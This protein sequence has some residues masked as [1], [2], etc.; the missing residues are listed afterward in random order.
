[1]EV[2]PLPSVGTGTTVALW[3]RPANP[4]LARELPGV[5]LFTRE[6]EPSI[7]LTTVADLVELE[8]KEAELMESES[9][10]PIGS[11]DISPRLVRAGVIPSPPASELVGT[12]MIVIGVEPLVPDTTLTD[13]IDVD[14]MVGDKG[15]RADGEG[16]P[17][18]G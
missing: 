7:P 17:S 14:H 2:D 4:L 12:P 3:G 13:P 5:Q 15:I 11:F 6:V 16:E 9:S 8:P 10:L 1:M 18:V